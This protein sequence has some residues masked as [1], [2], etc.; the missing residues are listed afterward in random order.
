MASDHKFIA[1]RYGIFVSLKSSWINLLWSAQDETGA[2][3]WID[4][5][6]KYQSDGTGLDMVS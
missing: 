3:G 4:F 6:V 2:G 1:Q 5:R